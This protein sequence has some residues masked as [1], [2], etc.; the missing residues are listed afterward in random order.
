M[1]IFDSIIIMLNSII[2]IWCI[3]GL[4]N[5]IKLEKKDEDIAF[6]HGPFA[7]VWFLVIEWIDWTSIFKR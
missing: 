3:I 4:L 5:Y 2:I 1:I 7:W 6:G